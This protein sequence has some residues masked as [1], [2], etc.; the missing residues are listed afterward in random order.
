VKTNEG[1]LE[2]LSAWLNG[3]SFAGAPR[4]V[5]IQASTTYRQ[6]L[7]RLEYGEHGHGTPRFYGK[8]ETVDGALRGALDAR[9][10]FLGTKDGEP[11]LCGCPEYT[12]GTSWCCSVCEWDGCEECGYARG[13]FYQSPGLPRWI[14]SLPG[15]SR[16]RLTRSRAFLERNRARHVPDAE[17]VRAAEVVAALGF[18]LAAGWTLYRGRRDRVELEVEVLTEKGAEGEVV[19]VAFRPGARAPDGRPL[20]QIRERVRVDEL[21]ATIETILRRTS[22]G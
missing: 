21:E 20:G 1:T 12:D 22:I 4:R 18:E 9:R 3:D 7:V 15:A 17:V 11:W 8:A 16:D 5:T 13:D 2:E 10:D 14:A 19:L 6:Y